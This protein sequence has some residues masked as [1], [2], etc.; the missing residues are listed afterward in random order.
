MGYGARQVSE[1]EQTIAAVECDLV[2]VGTPIDLERLVK[3]AKPSMRVRY[4]LDERAKRL[5]GIEIE[6]ALARSHV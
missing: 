4:E 6:R 5:L 1:L 3:I 2:L